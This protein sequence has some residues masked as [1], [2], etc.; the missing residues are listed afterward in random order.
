MNAVT[1]RTRVL[2]VDPA[3]PDPDLIREAAVLLR[4]G[5]LVAFPTETVYGLGANLLDPQAVQELYQVKQRPFEKQATLHIADFKQV[6]AEQVEITPLAWDL[7]RRFWPGPMTLVLP[8]L[9]GSTIGFRMPGHPVALALLKEAA[10]PVVAPSANLTGQ[11]PALT[12]E[13]V[14]KVFENQIDAVLD[15][16][17]AVSGI[18]STV[19]DLSAQPP[20]I[21][22]EGALAGE[23]RTLLE[24]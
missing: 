11:P 21:L 18:S 17:P 16:G 6:E 13:Q 20:R 3:N 5:G 1:G 14:L 2:K 7:M 8:R 15:G 19:V 4:R 23:I 22:R 12:A 9:D 24:R 10:V